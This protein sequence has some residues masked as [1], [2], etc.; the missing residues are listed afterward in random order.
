MPSPKTNEKKGRTKNFIV[1]GGAQGLKTAYW[2]RQMF[3]LRKEGI[4]LG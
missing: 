4:L 2:R 1:M 3:L